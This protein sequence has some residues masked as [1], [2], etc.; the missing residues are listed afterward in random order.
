MKI[1][2]TEK[3]HAGS[4][5][6]FAVNV[7]RTVNGEELKREFVLHPGSVVLAPVL[8]GGRI[9]LIRNYRHTLDQVILELPAGTLKPGEPFEVGAARELAE[10]TGFTAGR[11]IKLGD[12]FAAPGLT[13]ELMH[14]VLAEQLTAGTPSP[15]V[16]EQ[17]NVEIVPFEQ[18]LAMT[19]DGRI[20]DAKTMIGLEFVGRRL[21]AE[22]EG[23]VPGK[24]SRTVSR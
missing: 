11:L 5:F 19:R 1:L 13:N 6:D 15:E 22:R 20:R 10:E 14:I 12:Y 4:K 2:R 16:D 9:V 18:A 3:I 23:D 7:L 21:N 24:D 17:M 8:P